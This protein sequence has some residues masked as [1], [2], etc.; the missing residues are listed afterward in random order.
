MS[1]SVIQSAGQGPVKRSVLNTTADNPYGYEHG[2]L[3]SYANVT[4]KWHQVASNGWRGIH[5]DEWDDHVHVK[6]YKTINT[7]SSISSTTGRGHVPDV[8]V[9]EPSHL[10]E[11]S[12]LWATCTVVANCAL[13]VVDGTSYAVGTV[14]ATFVT[15]ITLVILITSQ[16]VAKTLL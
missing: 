3:A 11:P 12:F 8:A 5:P 4:Y 1:F 9:R 13:A 14:A 16:Q 10:D 2:K 15:A 7:T 6:N